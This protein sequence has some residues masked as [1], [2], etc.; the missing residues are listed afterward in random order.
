LG[1]QAKFSI[2][3]NAEMKILPSLDKEK[4]G[5]VLGI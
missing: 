5:V 3:L 2:S 4:S 1:K